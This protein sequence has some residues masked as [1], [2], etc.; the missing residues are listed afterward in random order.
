MLV[1][2][3]TVKRNTGEFE[4]RIDYEKI[5]KFVRDYGS[6]MDRVNFKV[7]RFMKKN[8][9]IKT[10]IIIGETFAH[11]GDYLVC[12]K[13]ENKDR[14]IEVYEGKDFEEKFEI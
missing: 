12:K 3:I 6:E 9:E 4:S 10:V 8:G 14:W 13:G 5:E 11:S 1:K 2:D 7:T